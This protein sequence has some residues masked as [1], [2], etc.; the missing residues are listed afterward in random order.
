MKR[1]FNR[2]ISFKDKSIKHKKTSIKNLFYELFYGCYEKL[3]NFD[4]SGYF[5]T[6]YKDDAIYVAYSP[7][8]LKK[9]IQEAKKFSIN[10]INFIDIGSGEN[11]PLR[12]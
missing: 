12:K 10:P 7:Y 11:M 3:K 5:H 6:I 1:S 4:F 8:Y 9:L 2:F